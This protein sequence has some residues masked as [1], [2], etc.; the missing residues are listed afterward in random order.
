MN[1][2]TIR[3]WY[4]EF[5]EDHELVE[6]RVLEGRSVYS[7]YFTDVE[8]ILK[9]LRSYDRQGC[10]FYW[11]LNSIDD[12]C[13]SRT[14]RDC[15]IKAA[16]TTQDD[17]IVGRDYVL[18]DIDSVRPSD[19]NA[20]DEQLK[21]AQRVGNEVYKFL[22]DEGFYPPACCVSGNGVHLLVRCKL[23][24]TKENTT[25]VEGFLKALDMLFSSEGAHVD[26]TVSNASRI[27]RLYGMKNRKGTDRDPLRPQRESVIKDVPL[28]FRENS[29]PLAYFKKVADLLP[30]PPKKDRFNNY[31]GEKFD[32]DEFLDKHHIEVV[33][34][35]EY[36]D[37]E[38]LVLDHCPFNETHRHPDACIYRM[39]NGAIA[40]HCSHNS[41]SHYHWR[42]F[43]LH[44]EPDAYDQKEQEEYER[45]RQYYGRY[46]PPPP[47]IKEENEETGKKWLS[48]S[49][50]VW[51]D[52]SELVSIQT[53]IVDLDK[54]IMGL[55]L[56]DITVFSGLSG[57]GKT[58]ILDHFILS[59]VQR[60][61]KVAC[62]SGELQDFR[63]Q[64]WLDQMAAGK[65][66]VR[67][68][69]G[70]ENYYYAPKDVCEK[71]NKWLDGKL[72][73]YNNDYGSHWSQIFNDIKECVEKNGTQL[74]LCD[75]L[76]MLN[77]DAYSGEKNDKQTQFITELKD[78]AKKAN[79]H[80]VLVCHPRKELSY[81]LLRKESIA[82]TA[83]LT[84]MADNV[85][86]SH[87]VGNDFER[88]AKDFFGEAR[89]GELTKYDVVLEVVK[90]RSVGIVDYLCGLY[91]EKETR[92]IKNDQAENIEYGWVE[93]PV[94]GTFRP[95]DTEEEEDLPEF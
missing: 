84:N 1:E 50:I 82:G 26:T 39:A 21:E 90:N 92:R 79:V 3:K 62:W 30:E 13:Y 24:N 49:D 34:R 74:I 69:Y 19:T 53:G 9:A 7:G 81:Q 10:N 72:F 66:F 48:M 52:P 16:T 11:T 95:D 42:D 27:C 6:I 77:L 20:T 25:V 8:N 85:I 70:Y 94:Q 12:A 17:N 35:T 68:S 56:G 83:D 60:N 51:K 37:G 57:S 86:I 47:T 23:Q 4:A 32:L 46:T 29:N 87:R 38:R 40:F 41:C 44:F 14:Q 88:R 5:K 63:F 67:Q 18:I 33:K 28:G 93:N 22:R 71:I 58:T 61:Y 15:M 65:R 43:R 78:F 75:N 91:Y 45:K 73:L 55:S 76:M 36:K 54:K 80:I 64:S 2:S 59:A 89:I 31:G